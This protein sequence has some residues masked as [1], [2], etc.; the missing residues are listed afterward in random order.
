MEIVAELKKDFDKV[1]SAQEL[2]D[3][4][5]IFDGIKSTNKRTEKEKFIEDN[6]SNNL[7]VTMLE[8]TYNQFITTGLSKK[9]ITKNVAPI[10]MSDTNIYEAIEYI[11]KNNTGT[12]KDIAWIKGYIELQDE[13]LHTFLSEFFTK[14]IKIG[15]NA[16]TVNKVIP[17]LIPQFGLILG[18]KYDDFKVHVEGKRFIITFKLD[19]MRLITIKKGDIIKFRSKEGHPIEGLIEL[20]EEAKKLKKDG[21]YDSE[22]VADGI[23]YCAREMY[24][25]TMKRARIKGIKTG[26]RMYCFDYIENEED[27]FNGVCN[28]PCEERKQQLC[29]II[30]DSDVNLIKY[31]K[32]LYIGKDT[33]VIRK[34][35]TIVVK[36]KQ[37]GLMINI[38][39]APY[40]CKRS[41]NLLKV[42]K[43]LTADLRIVGYE[44]T[45][46]NFVKP[47]FI[48]PD[49]VRLD[50]E[51]VEERNKRIAYIRQQID[52]KELI[53]ALV[54]DYKGH[55]VNV[56]SG[57]TV[58]DRVRLWDKRDEL[59]GT[60]VEV[61]Y[62]KESKNRNG[63][64][65][66]SC[67][68]F[69]RMRPDK[70][71]PSLH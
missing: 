63:G 46:K 27:F 22:L 10:S 47:D 31:L 68:T 29:D 26:L 15:I 49:E 30:K 4:M 44:Q 64:I 67:P 13:C 37:E 11:V 18:E 7:F 28:T 2:I 45:D 6:K 53:G 51:E 62:L 56:G 43:F 55:K 48:N 38:A 42:K 5:N 35:L 39:D 32:P 50:V 66:L 14:S 41:K 21:V 24:Q 59:I 12:N 69:S 58:W 36:S 61:Q 40:E 16:S 71:K 60:I 3:V 17:G 54:V 52:K 57:L 33:S 25:E 34:L 1:T 65:S 70:S 19:G 8:F 20:E 9:K 23:F